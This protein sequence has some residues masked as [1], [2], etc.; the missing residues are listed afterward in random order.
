MLS[1]FSL[2]CV[3]TYGCSCVPYKFTFSDF[4]KAT[5][6][7]AGV[8]GGRSSRSGGTIFDA[9]VE[10]PPM[11]TYEPKSKLPTIKSIIGM[12]RYHIGRGGGGKSV[13]SSVREVAKQVLAKWY[14]DTVACKSL[15]SIVREVEKLRAIFIDGKRRYARGEKSHSETAVKKYMELFDKKSELFDIY[16]DDSEKRKQVESE[17]GVNMSAMEYI[18]YDDQK[19]ERKWSALTG[20]TQCGII[21]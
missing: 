13:E 5:M 11:R 14:H 6:A 16:Q 3:I 20:R 17:W 9:D 10:F 19:S 1:Q 8:G 4:K 2:V 21:P 12:L 7:V 18:Y 15:S